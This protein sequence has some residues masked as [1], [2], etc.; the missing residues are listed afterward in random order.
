MFPPTAA[1]ARSV[2]GVG[3]DGEVGAAAQLVGGM[4]RG[5]RALREMSTDRCHQVS[6][7]GKTDH[8][9]FVRILCATAG[10]PPMQATISFDG[11]SERLKR[12]AVS[13]K[14][15][16]DL[17][18]ARAHVTI[19]RRIRHTDEIPDIEPVLW[20][21]TEFTLLDSRNSSSGP[22]YSAMEKWRLR[23]GSKFR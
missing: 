2:A 6:A 10:G 1:I 16:P 14:F 19:A 23:F 7:R 13:A 15:T 3:G 9:D 8:A 21:F 20:T 18:P 4:H 17:H 5:I 22:Q 11:L 12:E